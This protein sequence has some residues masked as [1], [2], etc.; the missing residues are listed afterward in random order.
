VDLLTS[1]L[2][3]VL[4]LGPIVWGAAVVIAGVIL[5]L[6]RRA[7]RAS[8][9]QG[10]ITGLQRRFVRA[11]IEKRLRP[12]SRLHGMMARPLRQWPHAPLPFYHGILAAVEEMDADPAPITAWPE[13]QRDKTVEE[14]A[15][16][17]AALARAIA[18]L[19][20]PAPI[21]GRSLKR[22]ARAARKKR[23][24]KARDSA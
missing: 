11:E 17:F 22:A 20:N 1:L 24:E 12:D 15:H 18:A 16:D 9:W 19:P 4:G 14:L 13:A 6:L 7:M 3:F 23:L 2:D 21:V 5:F 8:R 10:R